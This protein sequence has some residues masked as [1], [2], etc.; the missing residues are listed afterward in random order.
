[1]DLA[2]S[3]LAGARR[4][5][6]VEFVH[7][8]GERA[9]V[10][11]L[12]DLLGFDTQEMVDGEVLIGVVDPSTFKVTDN[13]NYLAGREVRPEQWAF[14]QA[15]AEALRQEPLASAYEGHKEM[16]AKTP[17]WGMHF[18][19]NFSSLEAWEAAVAR[20][21]DVDKHSPALKDRARLLAVFRPGDP[22][23]F[24]LYQAFVWTDVIASGSL[25]LSQRIELAC[26]VG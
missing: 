15:L 10:V 14:D 18:G 20:V 24:S 21:R 19:V 17:Q 13:D 1:M 16:L 12:F 8:P 22:G 3:Q 4:L 9:L 11:A 23:A 6:H 5:N 25:A 7:R 2:A 26:M